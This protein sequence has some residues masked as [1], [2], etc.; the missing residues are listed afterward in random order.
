M[1]NNRHAYLVIAHHQ[2]QL[3]KML[4]MLLDHP[5]HDIFVHVQKESE[6]FDFEDIAKATKYSKV[7]FTQRTT[8]RWGGYSLINCEFLLLKTAMKQGCYSYYHLVSGADLPLKT[9]DELYTFFENSGGK[10]F[11]DLQYGDDKWDAKMEKRIRY[12]Y[13]LRE[14]FNVKT[15]YAGV[16]EKKLVKLQAKLG[17]DRL[18]NL[19]KAIASGSQWFSITHSLAKHVVDSEEWVKQHFGFCGCGDEMFLQMLTRDTQFEKNVHHQEKDGRSVSNMRYI[20]WKRGNPY[21]FTKEDFDLLLNS[22]CMFAR[23]FDM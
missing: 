13:L 3:L 23:K 5:N 22:G 10:E 6:G 1:Q 19:D 20:D 8:V 12:Y 2:P 17:V 14:K 4:C 18:K 9:A 7:V 21:V 16:I 11:V 15:G